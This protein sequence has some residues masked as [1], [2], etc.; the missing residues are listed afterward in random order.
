MKRRR[1]IRIAGDHEMTSKKR[2]ELQANALL[3][4]ARVERER[5]AVRGTRFLVFLYPALS[6]CR[7]SERWSLVQAA[8][9]RASRHKAVL[10]GMAAVIA[11]G[12]AWSIAWAA[13]WARAEWL[14]WLMLALL[15]GT[16]VLQLLRTR[17]ELRRM[18]ANRTSTVHDVSNRAAN[19]TSARD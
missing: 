13:G 10:A 1:R 4:S 12:A 3:K 19:E 17:A 14:L 8:R 2:A 6:G 15:V 5:A 11:L 16:Q 7:A 9:A 18:L